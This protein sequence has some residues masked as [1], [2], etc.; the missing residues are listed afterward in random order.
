MPVRPIPPAAAVLLITMAH[1]AAASPASDGIGRQPEAMRQTTLLTPELVHDLAQ[2]LRGDG[3]HARQAASPVAAQRETEQAPDMPA[4]ATLTERPPFALSLLVDNLKGSISQ[5]V[6]PLSYPD[7]P[8][9]ELAGQQWA[10]EVGLSAK[11]MAYVTCVPQ[12]ADLPTMM[13]RRKA[14]LRAAGASQ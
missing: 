1:V 10:L 3:G 9:C 6:S 11:F 5:A 8:A 13:A 12:V 14:A 4:S 7:R 2:R